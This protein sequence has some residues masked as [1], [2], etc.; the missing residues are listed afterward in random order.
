MLGGFRKCCL[1]IRRSRELCCRRQVE[2]FEREGGEFLKRIITV[3]ET[4][5]FI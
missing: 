2:R 4:W 1:R 3:Y 5:I